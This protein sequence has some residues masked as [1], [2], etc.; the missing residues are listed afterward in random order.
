[1][2]RNVVSELME[3]HAQLLIKRVVDNQMVC[4]FC[5]LPCADTGESGE[6]QHLVS[7]REHAVRLSLSKVVPVS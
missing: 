4:G 2:I 5:A 6:A 1:M 3:I 7:T